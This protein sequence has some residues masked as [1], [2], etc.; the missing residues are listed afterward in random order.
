MLLNGMGI[1]G[2]QHSELNK[3]WALDTDKPGSDPDSATSE[4]NK[5]I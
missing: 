5:H 1:N 2:K 3:V 4:L